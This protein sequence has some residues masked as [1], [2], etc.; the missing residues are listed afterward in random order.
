VGFLSGT[1]THDADWRWIEPAVCRVLQSRPD[2]ELWL[3][4]HL[5]TGPAVAALG[6]RLRRLPFLDWRELPG[7]L[8]DLDVNLAPLEPGSRFN[9]AKSAIKWLEAALCATPTI[10]SPTEPFRAAIEDG[11][12]GLL[13]EEPGQWEIALHRLLDDVELRRA[14]GT[15]AQ[16]AALLGWAPALQAERHLEALRAA[17][18]ASRA[19]RRPAPTWS[20]TV[21]DE[22]FLD[23]PVPLEPYQDDGDG[24]GAAR[25]VGPSTLRRARAVARRAVGVARDE[26]FLAAA[27]RV[28]RSLR[29]RLALRRSR[30]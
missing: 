13:A 4:G 15:R 25:A 3:G 27:R 2:V 12:T 29:H 19:G 17:R 28:P 26:G 14:I 8:R 11:V 10:A 1:T 20:A 30:R 23:G 6:D 18:E 24:S 9:D 21:V 22:P 5:R 7:V 16:R